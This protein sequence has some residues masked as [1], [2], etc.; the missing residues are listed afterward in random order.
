MSTRRNDKRIFVSRVELFLTIQMILGLVVVVRLAYLQICQSAKYSLLSDRNRIVTQQTL[1]TRGRIYDAKGNVIATNHC[2]YSAVLDIHEIPKEKQAET[3]ATLLKHHSLSESVVQKLRN[4]P[5]IVTNSNRYIL[6]QEDLNW[7]ELSKYYITSSRIPGIVIEKN[8]VRKYIYPSEFSHIVGYT[9]SPTAYD[10]TNSGNSALSLPMAKIG[11]TCVEKQYNDELFGKAGIKHIEVNARRQFVRDIDSIA[12]IPGRDLNLTINLELQLEVYKILSQHESA[13]CVVMD[14]DTGAIIAMVSYPGYNTNIFTNKIDGAALK[15]LYDNPYKP[16]IN[17]VISG[18]YSPG[19]VFKMITALAGLTKGVINEN[20]RFNCTGY[21]EIGNHKFH[22][23]KW[24]S[25]GHGSVDLEDALAE[26]CDVYFYNVAKML[27]PDEIAA[28]ARDFG[29]GEPTGI[30]M[31]NEKSGLIPT[32]S[33]KK[34]KKKRSWTIGDT[35]NM[36]IGQGFV[37]T[38]PLQLAKMM[39]MLVNGQKPITPHLNK[40]FVTQNVPHLKYD[41]KHIQLIFDGMN[42]VVNSWYGT[43]HKSAIT[44][45]DFQFGGK[46]GSSQVFRITEALRR[47]GKT[48]SDDY[49]KKEHAVFV[50]YAPIDNPKFVVSVLVEHGGGGSQ[51]AAPIARDILLAFK[52]YVPKTFR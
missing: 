26:S 5:R 7:T 18:L 41:P 43:A 16:M 2:V 33:W 50:G 45:E 42:A 12:E 6:L 39:A 14:V 38:T 28:V 3:I 23:W 4:L 9:G 32:K 11:K 37:L 25:G 40:S 1:P 35:F 34:A 46:T 29:L 49:W 48:V 44:D 15:E 52:K 19:S 30:D 31:P 10:L 36:A 51:T 21:T 8:Q 17:K 13:S 24:K 22:C 20:T 27:S 47:A